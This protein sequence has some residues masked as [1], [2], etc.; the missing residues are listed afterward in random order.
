MATR[1]ELLEELR[2]SIE[3]RRIPPRREGVEVGT[4]IYGDDRHLMHCILLHVFDCGAWLV[5]IDMHNCPDQFSL[6][7][8]DWPARDCE[9]V[10]RKPSYL[11]VR[12]V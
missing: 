3:A 11:A 5:P 6:E 1:L 4:I 12:F 9:V 10:W 8:A 7:L 2:A